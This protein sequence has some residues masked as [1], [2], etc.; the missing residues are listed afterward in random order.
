ML[1]A[2]S[3]F[4]KTPLSVGRQLAM[5]VEGLFLGAAN[6]LAT[7]RFDRGERSSGG[8]SLS[9]LCR[10]AVHPS[11]RHRQIAHSGY[12]FF[13]GCFSPLRSGDSIPLE[14]APQRL[15]RVAT[16]ELLQG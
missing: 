8:I 16:A 13:P 3:T 1:A 5:S 4:K 14:P 9:C 10:D 12:F 2:I 6:E 11:E 7:S 15:Y